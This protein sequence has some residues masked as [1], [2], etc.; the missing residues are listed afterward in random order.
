MAIKKR[1]WLWNLVIVVTII[2]C[3]LAFAL[4]AKNWTR[5]EDGRMELISGFYYTAIPFAEIEKVSMVPKIPELE[6]INGFSAWDVEKGVFRDTLNKIENIRVYIDDLKQEKIRLD[7][8][9]SSIVYFNFTDSLRTRDFYELL[10]SK[11]VKAENK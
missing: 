3:L 7:R 5:V 8:K 6:R 11:I 2:I 1:H 4:H 10:T 9:D